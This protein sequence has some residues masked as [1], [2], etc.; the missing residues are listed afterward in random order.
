MHGTFAPMSAHT[1]RFAKRYRAE[2][3]RAA[4]QVPVAAKFQ[5][6]LHSFDARIRAAWTTTVSH[7]RRA[8]GLTSHVSTSTQLRDQD[9]RPASG[10]SVL[11]PSA[12]SRR[13]WPLGH[14][15]R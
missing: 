6:E 11:A 10:D 2:R 15:R 7:A 3:L 9:S 5:R 1:V 8:R 4:G 13:R 12:M 14:G